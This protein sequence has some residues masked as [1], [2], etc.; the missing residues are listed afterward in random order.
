MSML[1]ERRRKKKWSD[2]PQGNRWSKDN[3]KI[4]QK[5]LEKMG[6]TNGKGLGVN[7][8]GIKEHIRVNKRNPE[9]EKAGIGYDN[10]SHMKDLY[11]HQD[12]FNGLLQQLSKHYN[13]E[14]TVEKSES[15]KRDLSEQS[16]EL[17][18]KHSYARLH[19]QKFTRGKDVSKYKSKDLANI[20]GKKELTSKT[21]LNVGD[22]SI[23]ENETNGTKNNLDGVITINRGSMSDYFKQKLPNHKKLSNNNIDNQAADSESE[24][25]QRIGFR[26]T[27]KSENICSINETPKNSSEKS[28]YAFDNPCLGMNSP[29]ETMFNTEN[30][31]KKFRKKRKKEFVSEDTDLYIEETNEVNVEKKL[32]IGTIDSNYKDGF[33]NP[34]LNLDTKLNEACNGKEFE[35]SRAQFGLENCGLDLTDEKSDKKRVTFND[36]V[37]YNI[38]ATKKKKGKTTLDKFEVENKKHKKK[39]KYNI[40]NE[41][42]AALSNG[43]VNEALDVEISAEMND[44]ELNEHKSTKIKKRRIYKT[45]S[46]ETIQESPEREK[47]IIEMNLED[48]ISDITENKTDTAIKKSEKKKKNKKEIII[49]DNNVTGIENETEDN[50]IEKIIRNKKHK[51][52]KKREIYSKEK[53]KDKEECENTSDRILEKSETEQQHTNLDKIKNK[54]NKKQKIIIDN[55][56]KVEIL[57]VVT[58]IREESVTL[59]R[60]N[61]VQKKKKRN[62]KD[63]HLEI[64]INMCDVEKEISDKENAVEEE[65]NIK[66]PKKNKKHKRSKDTL[67]V[68]SSISPS[69]D[70]TD[71]NICHNDNISNQE[72]VDNVEFIDIPSRKS[73]VINFTDDVVHSPKDKKARMT[74]KI[75]KRL[76]YGNLIA[77]FPGSNIQEIK[78][79]GVNFN[80]N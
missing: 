42:I 26:F 11:E 32:K 58:T 31:L 36:H 19:Y 57:P 5:M 48:V 41:S 8:Q 53:K 4:G 55:S 79:Y 2:D 51:L 62:N 33:M 39:R 27:S 16:L 50:I 24:T 75:L 37:E 6:W 73:Q 61:A 43:F 30:S 17:K 54:K 14:E 25:K 38:D 12:K 72:N 13:Q 21:E 45:S 78:G 23:N 3:E 65:P 9:Y 71:N 34:A 49:I 64:E 60:E 40:V 74:K 77:D 22:N 18:S 59:E 1:A 76:F 28:N 7:E 44:N 68:E 20:F 63:S 80:G 35:V 47:E 56:A 66:L 10:D 67:D 29:M 52:D 70:I 46:L 69:A 15:N